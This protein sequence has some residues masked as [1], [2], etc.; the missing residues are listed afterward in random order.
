MMRLV[1]FLL[2]DLQSPL[3]SPF[4]LLSRLGDSAAASFVSVFAR[5]GGRECCVCPELE[6]LDMNVAFRWTL[7]ALAHF[8]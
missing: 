7:E 1:L 2:H 4:G 8:S 5:V 6:W 3:S